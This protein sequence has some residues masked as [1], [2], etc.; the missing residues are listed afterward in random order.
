[1]GWEEALEG[2][3]KGKVVVPNAKMVQQGSPSLHAKG[4]TIISLLG[5][6]AELQPPGHSHHCHGWCRAAMPCHWGMASC[7]GSPP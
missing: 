5:L 7:E 1:M 6:E 3:A 2:Q 4:F